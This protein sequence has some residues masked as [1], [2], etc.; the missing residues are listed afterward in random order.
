MGGIG[1]LFETFPSEQMGRVQAGPKQ[2]GGRRCELQTQSPVSSL[3][4]SPSRR[5]TAAF[6]SPSPSSGHLYTASV[7]SDTETD[8][9]TSLLS[10]PPG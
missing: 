2:E 3:S 5:W 8:R 4:L 1:C 10:Q 6:Q 9:N 7:H